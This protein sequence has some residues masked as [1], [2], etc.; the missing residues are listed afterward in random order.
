MDVQVLRCFVAV[1]DGATVTQAAAEAHLTQP[2]LSRALRRLEHE[3]G[4]ELFQQVGRVLRL[5]TAGRAFRQHADAALEQLDRGLRTVHETVSPESGLIP[6]A[7]LHSLGTWLLPPLITGFRERFPHARFELRQ[8]GEGVL[9]QI[10]LDGTADLLLTAGDPGHPLITWRRLL[11]E[12]LW[13]AVPPGHRLARR[14]RARLAEVA[15]EPFIMLRHEQGL[16]A[17]TETLCRTA[18]F[19][20][21]VG[22]EGDEVATLRGLV[23][24][25]LGVALVPRPH[26]AVPA[27]APSYLR[28]TDVHSARDIGIARLTSRTLPPSCARFLDHVREHAASVAERQH[29]HGPAPKNARTGP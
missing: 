18:G 7:F 20:P 23:G 11:V 26:A 24:A 29:A 13:L 19:T 2:A 21:H 14:R 27:D 25:G 1:A 17:V 12:P 9:V 16:R 4:A 22:F 3:V 8:A 28:V 6:L 15:D 5:T 10:L